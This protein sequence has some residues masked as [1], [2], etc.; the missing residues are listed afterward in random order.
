[1]FFF[2]WRMLGGR[3]LPH[4]ASSRL[5]VLAGPQ[6]VGVTASAAEAGERCPPRPALH[7]EACTPGRRG[8]A[9]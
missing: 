9:P 4:C 5:E 8:S 1:M 2:F 3:R 7:G 6:V